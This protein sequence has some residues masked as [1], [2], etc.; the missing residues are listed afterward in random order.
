[1]V[2]RR[3]MSD[4]AIYGVLVK[5]ATLGRITRLSPHDSRRTFASELIDASGDLYAV[6][7]LLG[8]SNIATTTRYDRRLE[9]ANAGSRYALSF[10]QRQ[11]Q[12]RG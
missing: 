7:Q 5:R 3:A 8:H 11:G 1:M 9:Q 12:A 10:L 6:Q 2:E 4:Q